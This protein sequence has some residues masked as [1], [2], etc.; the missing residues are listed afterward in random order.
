MK[1]YVGF[2]DKAKTWEAEGRREG[3]ARAVSSAMLEAVP[4]HEESRVLDLGA[5]TGLISR[6]L[7]RRVGSV[8][9]LDG[10]SAMVAELRARADAEEIRNIEALV[11][12]VEEPWPVKGEFD[13]VCGSMM[14][15]HVAETSALFERARRVLV[16]GGWIAMA[17]LEPEDGDFHEGNHGVHHFGFEQGALRAKLEAGGFTDIAFKSVTTMEKE[18]GGMTKSYRIFL[19]T[20]RTSAGFRD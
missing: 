7:A 6:A 11:A 14:L 5:G 18:R 16:S 13:L 8:V 20:A 2:E 9:A 17:D 10:A 12:D 1:G 19:V 15:H 3:L 4:L